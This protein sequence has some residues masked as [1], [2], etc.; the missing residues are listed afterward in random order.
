VPHLLLLGEQRDDGVRV[1]LDCE[2]FDLTAGH[3]GGAQSG[4]YKRT[5]KMEKKYIF[6][7]YIYFY[8]SVSFG[9]FKMFKLVKRIKCL[10]KCYLFPLP[11][12]SERAS[13]S[14]PPRL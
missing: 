4:F 11:A 10:K 6:G 7:F 9:V 13:W 14:L 5:C 3:F 1:L 8:L 12:P 2:N